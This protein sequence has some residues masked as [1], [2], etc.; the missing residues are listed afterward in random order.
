M[1]FLMI[2][3]WLSTASN[4]VVNNVPRGRC[5]SGTF[6]VDEQGFGE[7]S[8]PEC[9]VV[10]VLL[11]WC[12]C[13]GVGC[14]DDELNIIIIIIIKMITIT[15]AANRNSSATTTT[16]APYES[17]DGGIEETFTTIDAGL[18]SLLR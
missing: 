8:S 12:V 13:G 16:T 17:N 14:G 6:K 4:C 11:L 5:V 3:A 10:L 2:E 9:C 1:A 15:A 18:L 7:S